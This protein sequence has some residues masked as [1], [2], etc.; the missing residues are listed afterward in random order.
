MDD[1]IVTIMNNKN[2]QHVDAVKKMAEQSKISI[3][4]LE[5]VSQNVLIALS[6]QD[7][8]LGFL[9]YKED[10]NCDYIPASPVN[11][12]FVMVVEVEQLENKTNILSDFYQYLQDLY[13]NHEIYVRTL[14]SDTANV[15]ILTER[16]FVFHTVIENRNREDIDVICFKYDPM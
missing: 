4:P 10:Y 2:K 14:S 3:E 8:V 6:P 12:I 15:R 16:G 13:P 7:E 5:A 9:A 1:M 11:N